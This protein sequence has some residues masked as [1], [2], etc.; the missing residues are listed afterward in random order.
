[1]DALGEG[2]PD[3]VLRVPPAMETRVFAPIVPVIPLFPGLLSI[4]WNRP[5]V[6]QNAGF[7]ITPS[8]PGPVLPKPGRGVIAALLEGRVDAR[9]R[10]IKAWR[11]VWE[12]PWM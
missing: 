10:W 2:W 9:S 12:L 4:P 5:A 8:A 1:M 11:D 3:V 6:F 7:R